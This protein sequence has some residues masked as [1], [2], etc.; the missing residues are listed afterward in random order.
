MAAYIRCSHCRFGW[1]DFH[2]VDKTCSVC[3]CYANIRREYGYTASHFSEAYFLD[4]K[5]INRIVRKFI[6]TH[7]RKKGM[8][9]G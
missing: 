6:K 1:Y 5:Q 4:N 2:E 3:A 9:Y 8:N 7:L